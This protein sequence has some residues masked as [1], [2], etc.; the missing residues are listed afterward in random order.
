[1]QTLESQAQ[2]NDYFG[3]DEQLF[4]AYKRIVQECSKYATIVDAE[5]LK[6][7]SELK[8]DASRFKEHFLDKID[9]RSSLRTQLGDH[10]DNDDLLKFDSNSHLETLRAMLQAIHAGKV[11]PRACVFESADLVRGLLSDCFTIDHNLIQDDEDLLRMSPGK[12]GIILFQLFL[13]LSKSTNPILIDQPEDNLDNRNRIPGVERLH[14]IEED[15]RG[16]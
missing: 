1:M 2:A 4:A 10:F 6:L 13:H 9:K 16:K 7:V 12:R 11:K 3:F 14:K 15:E 8:L 5:N